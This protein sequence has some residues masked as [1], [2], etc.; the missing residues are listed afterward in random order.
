MVVQMKINENAILGLDIGSSKICAV[1]AEIDESNELQ[2][3]GLGSSITAGISR[4]AII[5]ENELKR[6]IDRAIV[7]A[8][9]NANMKAGKVIVNI[10][11]GGFKFIT[12]SGLI[13]VADPEGKIT[14]ADQQAVIENAKKSIAFPHKKIMHVIPLNYKVD[15]QDTLKP[16]AAFGQHLEV[17]AHIILGDLNNIIIVSKIMRNFG[18]QIAGLAYDS[19]STGQILL[20]DQERQNGMAVLDIGGRFTKYSYFVNDRLAYSQII[21]IGGETITSDIAYC[22]KV[23]IPEAE[24]L[25]VMYGNVLLSSID[26]Q[27]KIEITTIN[28]GRKE[29]KVI[30][31]GQIINARLLELTKMLNEQ[32]QQKI[33]DCAIILAGQSAKLKGLE[34]FLAE[35]LSRTVILDLPT[36]LRSLIDNISYVSALSLVMY[37]LKNKAFKYSEIQ[38]R[39]AFDAVWQKFKRNFL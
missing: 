9:L 32:S 28:E 3:K 29:I 4:G 23:T 22:L 12:N 7:R 6:A 34:S 25:K 27:E 16:E 39:N 33:P 24:R 18:L 10:P 19:L 36:N 17:D 8:E 31:L 14:F 15:G 35:K 20:T 38:P 11:F 30:L 2:V 26:K 5:D 13:S 21:P 37:G 1:L